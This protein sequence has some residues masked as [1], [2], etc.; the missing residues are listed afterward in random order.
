MMFNTQ[1]LG[2]TNLALVEVVKN[3]NIVMVNNHSDELAEAANISRTYDKN[4]RS[5][6]IDPEISLPPKNASAL[7]EWIL[8]IRDICIILG[9]V[10]FV[11]AYI[12]SPFTISG[13]SMESSYHNGEFILVDKLSYNL[14][15]W[16]NTVPARGDVVVIEP[17]TRADKQ[18]YIKRIIGMPGDKVRIANG[19]VSIKSPGVADFIELNEGYLSAL[20][21][22]KTYQNRLSESADYDVPT[23]KYFIMGDNRNNSTDARDCFASCNAPGASPYLSG[24]NISGRLLITLGSLRIFDNKSIIPL[25]FSLAD[26]IGFEVLPRFLDSPKTWTYPELASK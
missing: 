19:K 17:H 8:F 21:Q 11:R 15:Q 2:E 13:S 16:T 26:S 25:N 18:Y 20:N 1:E 3:L 23:G 22:G 9:I 7:S 14:S 5:I 10:I 4:S 6:G 12:M 24:E